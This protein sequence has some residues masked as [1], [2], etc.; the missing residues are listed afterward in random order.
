ET[1]P[2]NAQAH[3]LLGQKYALTK[4]K[5]KA[6][7][8]LRKAVELD[9]QRVE[10]HT[11]L[12]AVLL[13]VGRTVDA[14]TAGKKAIQANPRSMEAHLALG[15]F[16]LAQGKV[17]QAEAELRTGCE[18]DSYAVMPRL[19][20]ARIY[21]TTGR[22]TDAEKAYEELKVVAPDDPQAYRALGLFYV[23]T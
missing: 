13:S 15:Q 6:I 22:L 8:E 2:N 14:E 16:Y 10:T 23:S 19:L 20:L 12:A 9:P 7:E 18:L 21:T 5:E 11:A 17:A 1:E 4:D 3:A